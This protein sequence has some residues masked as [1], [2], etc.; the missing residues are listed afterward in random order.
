MD[1]SAPPASSDTARLPLGATLDRHAVWPLGGIDDLSPDLDLLIIYEIDN[2]FS[3]S[4]NEG[5]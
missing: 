4:K 5:S 3:F 1:D 2:V